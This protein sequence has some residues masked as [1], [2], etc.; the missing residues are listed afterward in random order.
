MRLVL[1]A[2]A[3]TL[4]AAAPAMANEVRVEAHSGVLW[5]HDSTDATAG[6]AAGYDYDLG[7]AAFGGVEVSAD[8]ILN[9][10][11]KRV[12]VGV[13]GRLGANL[14]GTKLYAVG[15]YATTPCS[16]CGGAWNFGAG[17]Q[18]SFL[19]KFYGKV[20]YRHYIADEGLGNRDAV[21]AGVGLKF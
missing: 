16:D 10:Y 17:V 3:G 4:A 20:E 14:A 6:V 13:S 1:L 2:L 5:N 19:Q 18:K 15:G 8:K 21:T 9:S 12:S 7:P 11:A